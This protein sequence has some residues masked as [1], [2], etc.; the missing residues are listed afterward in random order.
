MPILQFGA[1]RS[2]RPY[3]RQL[4]PSITPRSLILSPSRNSHLNSELTSCDHFPMRSPE[5]CPTSPRVLRLTR[6]FTTDSHACVRRYG[7]QH[8]CAA[9]GSKCSTHFSLIPHF[10]RLGLSSAASKLWTRPQTN[11]TSTLMLRSSAFHSCSI[12]SPD[13]SWTKSRPLTF[14]LG[15]VKPVLYR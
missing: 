6:A 8:L 7:T 11:M 5:V 14:S 1:N 15:L 4:L 2:L 10:R 3:I 9:S 12:G 13:W